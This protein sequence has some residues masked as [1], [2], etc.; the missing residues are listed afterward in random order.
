MIPHWAPSATRQSSSALAVHPGELSREQG[1]YWMDDG[2]AGEKISVSG[3]HY[4]GSQGF[5]TPRAG[6]SG[7][8]LSVRSTRAGTRAHIP[9]PRHGLPSAGNITVGHHQN[10]HFLVMG[11]K[12]GKRPWVPTLVNN[13]MVLD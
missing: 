5:T 1:L 7:T 3:V 4:S 2:E 10:K 12:E 8:E 13:A 6:P 11:T 9:V